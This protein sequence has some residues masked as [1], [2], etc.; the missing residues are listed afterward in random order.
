MRPTLFAGFLIISTSLHAS[1]VWVPSAPQSL[2]PSSAREA[3]S[4]SFAH[5]DPVDR[6]RTQAYA[7]QALSLAQADAQANTASAEAQIALAEC[8]M[9]LAYVGGLDR[10]I[11]TTA[12]TLKA[13]STA[14][15]LGATEEELGGVMARRQMYMASAMGG[16]LAKA[17]AYFEAAHAKDAA[18]GWNAYFCGEALR[19]QGRKKAA[20]GWFERALEADPQHPLAGVGLKRLR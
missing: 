17:A 15:K 11:G 5:P 13:L 3:W 6:A 8:A 4:L 12:S 9:R 16:D 10:A 18:G 1:P 2:S 7:L 20:R 14:R 19:Q